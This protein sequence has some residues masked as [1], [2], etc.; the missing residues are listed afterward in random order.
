MT[1]RSAATPTTHHHRHL[2]FNIVTILV[3]ATPPLRLRSCTHSSRMS[4]KANATSIFI[5]RHNATA[6]E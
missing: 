4:R 3:L 5:E 1:T 2:Q 6:T